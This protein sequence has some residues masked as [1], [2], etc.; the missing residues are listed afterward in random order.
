MTDKGSILIGYR[1]H[2]ITMDEW[3]RRKRERREACKRWKWSL[4]GIGF[5]LA[6]MY[7]LLRLDDL[8]KWVA[9]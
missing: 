4:V 2:L 5:I 3:R 9:G 6:T 1:G 8:A 7:L